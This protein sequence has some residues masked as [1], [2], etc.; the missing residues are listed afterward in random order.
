MKNIR[1][2]GIWVLGKP[3]SAPK[4]IS[5]LHCSTDIFVLFFS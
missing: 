5:E 2:S 1:F 3:E 4:N